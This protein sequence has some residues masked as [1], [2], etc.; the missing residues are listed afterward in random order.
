MKVI[1]LDID[2]VMNYENSYLRKETYYKPLDNDNSTRYQTFGIDAKNLINKLILETNAKV[3]ISSSWRLGGE[4]YIKDVWKSE[5]MVGEIIGIT[6]ALS[7]IIKN[8]TLAR[9]CE[10]DY[11]LENNQNIDTYVIID[12]DEDMLLKQKD[13]F[14]HVEQSPDNMEGFNED[15]YNKALKILNN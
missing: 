4:E 3:V 12:D 5:K 2:G 13:N 1:F 14:V 9:G 10:I 11:Y 7:H 6:P 15:C 8:Y